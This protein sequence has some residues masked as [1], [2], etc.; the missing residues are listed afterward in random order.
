MFN[1]SARIP[2]A[3]RSTAR[4]DHAHDELTA[5]A[6]RPTPRRHDPRR[7]SRGEHGPDTDPRLAASARRL[8]PPPD[9]HA[10]GGL[11]G[12]PAAGSPDGGPAPGPPM[13]LRDRAT[14]VLGAGRA[15]R[16]RGAS[17]RPRL[18]QPAA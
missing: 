10:T 4:E 15:A 16:V 7:T 18:V 12:R 8:P 1:F 11:R 9:R 6:T 14:G 17:P 13:D 2:R 5:H 3:I